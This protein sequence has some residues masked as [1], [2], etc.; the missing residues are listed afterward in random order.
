MDKE[1]N[2][3]KNIN[4]PSLIECPYCSQLMEEA[5]MP[6]LFYSDSQNTKELRA[7]LKLLKEI[8]ANGYNIVTCG[9]CGQVLIVKK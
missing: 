2:L 3:C 7:Q 1:L 6:D 4:S 8:Q 5:D 9:N